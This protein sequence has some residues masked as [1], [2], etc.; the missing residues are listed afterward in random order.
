MEKHGPP[1][2]SLLG[3]IQNAMARGGVRGWLI[4]DVR[5]RN[6]VARRLFGFE[7]ELPEHR[8]FYWIPTEG[9]PLAIAHESDGPAL[10][11]LP[12]ECVFYR[13]A[14]ELRNRL[15]RHL[16]RGGKILVES[17]SFAQVAEI[18]IVDEA[19]LSLIRS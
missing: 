14:I 2:Y 18:A 5:G 12:G 17:G 10:P 8:F 11:E 16:P 1:I 19:T 9:L 15:E 4:Y 6:P 3:P 7:P 13:K